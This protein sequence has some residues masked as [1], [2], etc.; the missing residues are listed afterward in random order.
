V[1]VDRLVALPLLP[2]DRQAS[3]VDDQPRTLVDLDHLIVRAAGQPFPFDELEQ[4]PNDVA[5]GRLGAVPLVN[6]VRGILRRKIFVVVFNFGNISSD[7]HLLMIRLSFSF[8]VFVL[9]FSFSRHALFSFL[10]IDAT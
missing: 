10:G 9:A 7:F 5:L 2:S 4:L 6:I 3:H 8:V 1:V